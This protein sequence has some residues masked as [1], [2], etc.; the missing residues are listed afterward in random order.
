MWN[1]EYGSKEPGQYSISQG[2]QKSG[3]MASEAAEVGKSSFSLNDA[4]EVVELSTEFTSNALYCSNSLGQP[5]YCHI[6][7]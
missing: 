1:G 5:V 4:K 6:K 3:Y 2:H 7:Y